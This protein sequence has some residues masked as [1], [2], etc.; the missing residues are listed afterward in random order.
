[1]LLAFL[2]GL[3]LAHMLTVAFIVPPLV[4]VILWQAPWLLRSLRTLMLVTAA[5]LLPLLS[6]G[7]VYMRGAAH[8]EWWGSGRWANAQ[9]WFWSFVGTAQG[10]EELGWGFE[11]GRAFLGNGFPELIWQELSIPI[12]L[13]GLLGLFLLDRRLRVLLFGTLAIY[14][15]FNWAYR[16]GNWFQVILPAY[17]LLLMGVMAVGDRWQQRIGVNGTPSRWRQ[18]GGWAPHLLLI[19]AIGWRLDASLPAADSRNRPEDMDL[20]RPAKLLGQPLPPGVKLFAALDDAL[21]LQYLSQIWGVRPDVVVVS[22]REAADALR[23]QQ[24]VL[25]TWESAGRLA[26]EMPSDLGFEVQGVGPDWVVLAPPGA[27]WPAEPFTPMNHAIAP[28]I[29]LVGVRTA[30]GPD[31][32]PAANSTETTLDVTL[33]WRLE[34]GWPDGMGISVRP[35]QQGAFLADPRTPGAIVQQDRSGPVHGLLRLG[36]GSPGRVVA[37]GYRFTLAEPLPEGADG[38]VVIVYRSVDGGFE[39]LAEIRLPLILDTSR[40]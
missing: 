8:P 24:A 10:R 36:V 25:A 14:L 34:D 31:G 39:N 15:V 13:I 16:Y 7:Y 33:F 38:V 17:P 30:T 3:S 21:S 32:A 19:L 1:M 11:P 29:T 40:R 28:G 23:A 18:I 5:A 26:D 20:S 4:A 9:E 6:Y 27:T 37:D 12:L 2:C 35:T 22:R